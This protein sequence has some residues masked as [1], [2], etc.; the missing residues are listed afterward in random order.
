MVRG[1]RSQASW[2]YKYAK[3]SIRSSCSPSPSPSP[4]SPVLCQRGRSRSSQQVILR[5]LRGTVGQTLEGN[6]MPVLG[7]VA[8][9][10]AGW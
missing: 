7:V 10:R 4:N 8:A 5:A 1:R 6:V 9:P 2:V 3:D